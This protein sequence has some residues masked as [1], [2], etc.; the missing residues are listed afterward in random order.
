M[1]LAKNKFALA[2][3]GT[4]GI[5]Y[6]IC[7]VVVAI[8]PAFALKLFGW[9][10]HLVSADQFTARV[11]AIGFVIGLIQILVYSYIAALIFA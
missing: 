1:K 4:L 10:L 6:I 11:T 5:V 2:A 8:A 7:A 9:L 3:A